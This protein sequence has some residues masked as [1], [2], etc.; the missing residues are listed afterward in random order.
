LGATGAA[1]AKVPLMIGDTADE[2][3]Y[4]IF[5]AIGYLDGPA[6]MQQAYDSFAES[7]LSG[8]KETRA[9]LSPKER[10][11]AKK[12]VLAGH[13][14]DAWANFVVSGNPSTV[15]A[16]W[17]DYDTEHRST[18]VFSTEGPRAV[19]DPLREDR[20]LLEPL[21]HYSRDCSGL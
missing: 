10:A 5:E 12:S 11:I 19:D 18:M 15:A 16:E 2:D 14:V 20:V 13:A 17:P 3:K 7:R 4:D 8:W 21:F 1:S 6:T 9:K